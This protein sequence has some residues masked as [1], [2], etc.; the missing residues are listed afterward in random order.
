MTNYIPIQPADFTDG[1]GNTLVPTSATTTVVGT[2]RFC[3]G[4]ECPRLR[5]TCSG[6]SFQVRIAR[7]SV[8]A[9]VANFND[10]PVFVDGVYA[11][12]IT[13]TASVVA[14]YTFL[15]MS[16][17]DHVVEIQGGQGGLSGAAMVSTGSILGIAGTNIKLAKIVAARKMI[18]FGDSIIP[19]NT[20]TSPLGVTDILGLLRTYYPGR[21]TVEAM[22]S[23]TYTMWSDNVS[24]ISRFARHVAGAATFDICILLGTNDYGGQ[25]PSLTAQL[26]TQ[27][28]LMVA[29]ANLNKLLVVTPL[30]RGT[31]TGATTLGQYRA[32]ITTAI[33]AV[34]STKIITLDGTSMGLNVNTDYQETPA[35]NALHPNDFGAAK[36]FGGIRGALGF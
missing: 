25:L 32:Q 3:C 26:T 8:I 27:F 35:A 18:Y 33:A 11:G 6:T 34:A 29:M 15:G 23:A 28:A 22:G 7:D 19:A 17:G 4:T 31:E 10:C 21:V 36:V 20:G 24:L 12:K 30:T 14:W 2:D 9:G 16:A 13:P 5:F 1:I